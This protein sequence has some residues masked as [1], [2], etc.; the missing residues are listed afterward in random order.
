MPKNYP[1]NKKNKMGGSSGR[2]PKVTGGMKKMR[3]QKYTAAMKK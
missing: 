1:T 2:G 3:R